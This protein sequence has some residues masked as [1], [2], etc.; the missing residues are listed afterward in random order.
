[1]QYNHAPDNNTAYVAAISS[2]VNRIFTSTVKKIESGARYVGPV[3][4]YDHSQQKPALAVNP[5]VVATQQVVQEINKV[6]HDASPA[7]WADAVKQW[8]NKK[9][10]DDDSSSD[11]LS[12]TKKRKHHKKCRKHHKKSHKTAS[13]PVVA[14]AT[15]AAP[16]A[17][18]TTPTEPSY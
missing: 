12:A 13:V 10:G 3:A 14:P 15:T 16:V 17:V 11:D 8:V 9:L 4:H 18:P 5:I 6:A 2:H 1:M 7:T